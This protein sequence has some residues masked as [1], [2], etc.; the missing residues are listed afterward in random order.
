MV[1]FRCGSVHQ[2]PEWLISEAG[3]SASI[4]ES[5]GDGMFCGMGFLPQLPDWVEG[6]GKQWSSYN[7]S[8]PLQEFQ[9]HGMV[10]AEK[11][12]QCIATFP[13]GGGV[14]WRWEV[15]GS[16]FPMLR[17][18][19]GENCWT[20]E[21]AVRAGEVMDFT[22][23]PTRLCS[24]YSRHTVFLAALSPHIPSPGFTNDGWR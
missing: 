22:D 18:L 24:R 17:S 15:L 5:S 7:W 14:G 3:Q 9:A 19:L 12:T 10:S 11:A 1:N 20:H 4:A 2:K 21:K 8:M 6:S 13:G 23:E 16:S